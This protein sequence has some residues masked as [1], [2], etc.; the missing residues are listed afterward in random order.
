MRKILEDGRLVEFQFKP[1]TPEQAQK[2]KERIV[3]IMQKYGIKGFQPLTQKE[4]NKVCA[5]CTNLIFVYFT[6]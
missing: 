4:I 1:E 2:R 3:K 5:N 6:Y